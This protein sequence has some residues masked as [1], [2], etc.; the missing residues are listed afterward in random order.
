MLASII[1]YAVDKF[2]IKVVISGVSTGA[3]SLTKKFPSSMNAA[4]NVPLNAPDI[5]VSDE[6]MP[7]LTTPAPV[8]PPIGGFIIS[9]AIV[10]VWLPTERTKACAKEVPFDPTQPIEVWKAAA[11]PTALTN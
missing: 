7:G 8:P 5:E 9:W 10:A 2:V 3:T 6:L 11:A 4:V 1:P